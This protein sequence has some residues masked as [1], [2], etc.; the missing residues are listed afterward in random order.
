MVQNAINISKIESRCK[1]TLFPSC[2]TPFSIFLMLFGLILLIPYSYISILLLNQ[3]NL[4][5]NKFKNNGILFCFSNMI[6][7]ICFSLFSF[8]ILT[9]QSSRLIILT[10]VVRILQDSALIMF[11]ND[12]TKILMMFNVIYSKVIYYISKVIQYILVFL[13]FVFYI[14]FYFVP[15]LNF[16]GNDFFMYNLLFKFELVAYLLNLIMLIVA[17]QF[18][19]LRDV[20]EPRKRIYFDI[21]LFLFLLFLIIF[22]LL[23]AWLNSNYYVILGNSNSRRIITTLWFQ[24]MNLPPLAILFYLSTAKNSDE[25]SANLDDVIH[26]SIQI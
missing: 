2:D 24:I 3:I 8:S 11:F 23:V 5:R 10:G 12:I 16:E 1:V 22:V 4:I 26:E 17:F 6:C 21:A 19:Y 7:S 15:S 9:Y 14:A 18:S 20:I 25:K 13:G